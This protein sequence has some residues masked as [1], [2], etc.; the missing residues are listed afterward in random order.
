ML[1]NQFLLHTAN[2]V[3]GLFKVSNFTITPNIFSQREVSVFFF[4]LFF[5]VF[6]N[7]YQTIKYSSC[8]VHQIQIIFGQRDILDMRDAKLQRNC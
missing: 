4:V 8:W 7:D 5:W 6:F 2:L 1:G 3:G